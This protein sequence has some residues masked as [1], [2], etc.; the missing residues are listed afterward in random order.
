MMMP[1]TV[2]KL[3]RIAVVLSVILVCVSCSA[4]RR[5]Q[6]HIH[7]AIELCPELVQKEVRLID[8]TLTAPSFSDRADVPFGAVLAYDSV[9]VRT[10]HGRVMIALDKKGGVL[11]VEYSG[12]EQQIRYQDTIS[13]SQVVVQEKKSDGS[14]FWSAFSAWIVGAAIGLSLALW[15]LRNAFKNISSN[16]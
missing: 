4:Q 3:F 9:A 11:R 15:M 12:D 14:G 7:R 1:E 16:K 6:R 13:Y 2:K 5:A 10:E 8:T